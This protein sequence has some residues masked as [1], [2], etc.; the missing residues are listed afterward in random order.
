MHICNHIRFTIFNWEV[1]DNTVSLY[2]L[3]R[4]KL[5]DA[6]GVNFTL[7]LNDLYVLYNNGALFKWSFTENR[8]AGPALLKNEIDSPIL[9]ENESA[10]DVIPVGFTSLL[11]VK[12]TRIFLYKKVTREMLLFYDFEAKILACTPISD[13]L[14]VLTEETIICLKNLRKPKITWKMGFVL[15]T[16]LRCGLKVNPEVSRNIL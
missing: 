12:T 11:I 4:L 13:G 9:M 8:S 14:L 16:E 6:D 5:A 10:V 2:K 1:C 15:T 3:S 7:C